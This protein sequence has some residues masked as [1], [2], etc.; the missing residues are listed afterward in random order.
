MYV[1]MYDVYIYESA[2]AYVR[3]Y[4]VCD[5]YVCVCTRVCVTN[6]AVVVEIITYKTLIVIAYFLTPT[7]LS[8]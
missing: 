7:A 4:D 6:T 8:W 3:M 2:G 5:I 1:H